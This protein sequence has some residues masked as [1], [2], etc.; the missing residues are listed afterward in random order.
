MIVLS[1]TP[2]PQFHLLQVLSSHLTKMSTHTFAMCLLH[3]T[4]QALHVFNN[5][6]AVSLPVLLTMAQTDAN[7]A[8]KLSVLT[9]VL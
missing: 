9:G 2:H 7:V 3:G 6:P 1:W 5:I 4:I 8:T